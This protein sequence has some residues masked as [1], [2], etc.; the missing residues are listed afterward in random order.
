M[1]GAFL[2]GGAHDAARVAVVLG[3]QRTFNQ[4][5]LID[6]VEV[7]R[8]GQR[9]ERDV[10]RVGAVDQEARLLRLRTTHRIGSKA[11]ARGLYAR[12]SQFQPCKVAAD[13]RQLF[14]LLRVDHVA[15]L[16]LAGIHLHRG[17]VHL[18]DLGLRSHR[19]VNRFLILLVDVEGDA[20]GRK[21]LERRCR[22]GDGIRSDREV[23][24]QID[25]VRRRYGVELYPG[26]C[27]RGRDSDPGDDCSLRIR[28]HS[29]DAAVDVCRIGR[30]QRGH[31]AYYHSNSLPEMQLC[32]NSRS[33]CD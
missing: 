14:H 31:Q 3:V 19:Q 5:E 11:I 8:D 1:V 10:I 2:N 9:I 4:V 30:T 28:N 21:S 20:V 17:G 16:H 13:Q 24:E 25:A 6:G 26:C 15:Q 29:L 12:Q 33:S 23:R 7:R 22:R 32:H 27:I 18:H